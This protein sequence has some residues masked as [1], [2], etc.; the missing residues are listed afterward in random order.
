[1]FYFN[2]PLFACFKLVYN[3]TEQDAIVTT[4]NEAAAKEIAKINNNTKAALAALVH[5]INIFKF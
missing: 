4:R 1:L 3:Q 2:I 5:S